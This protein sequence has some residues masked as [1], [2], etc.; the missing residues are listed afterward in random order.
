[1]VIKTPRAK[2]MKVQSNIGMARGPV[3]HQ[4]K[5]SSRVLRPNWNAVQWPRAFGIDMTSGASRQRYQSGVRPKWWGRRG[6]L[7][8]MHREIPLRLDG[9]YTSWWGSYISPLYDWQRSLL[10]RRQTEQKTTNMKPPV[11]S[12]RWRQVKGLPPC[13]GIIVRPMLVLLRSVEISRAKD[14]KRRKKLEL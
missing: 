6:H 10:R 9:K 1:L 4:Q 12:L 7:H 5:Q 2:N 8:W 3:L 11:C 13:Q 14:R